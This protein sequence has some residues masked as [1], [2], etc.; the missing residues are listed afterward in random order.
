[1]RSHRTAGSPPAQ[2]SGT[3]PWTGRVLGLGVTDVLRIELAPEQVPSLVEQLDVLRDVY[4]DSV[5]HDRARCEAIRD[6]AREARLPRAIQAEK[7]LDASEFDLEA[8]DIIAS[9]VREVDCD[10]PG[11]VTIHG[12]SR[13]IAELVREA[14][15]QA[16]AKLNELLASAPRNEADAREQL[17]AAGAAV[18]AWTEIY[19]ECAAVEWFKFDLDPAPTGS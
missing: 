15:L 2:S 9:Q 1:M 18:K 13:I 17:V 19:V 14:T 5:S 11:P 4:K 8:L 3:S 6:F 7:D 16:A 10:Q 12:P